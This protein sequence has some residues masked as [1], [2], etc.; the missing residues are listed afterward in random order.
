MTRILTPD[1]PIDASLSMSETEHGRTKMKVTWISMPI[2][3][4]T[5]INSMPHIHCHLTILLR[6]RLF[7]EMINSQVNY[8]PENLSPMNISFPPSH[9]GMKFSIQFT[10][11][12]FRHLLCLR[13][14]FLSLLPIMG[15]FYS[16]TH[17]L[18]ILKYV[19]YQTL[20]RSNGK[21]LI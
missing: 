1:L 8:I 2:S 14:I 7:H 6:W 18:G 5:W 21:G 19:R 17:F 13:M 12:I 11:F 15:N 16:P 10:N 4:L 20:P 3:Y 9:L